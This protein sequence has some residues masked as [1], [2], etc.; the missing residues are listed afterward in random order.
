MRLLI[1][2]CLWCVFFVVPVSAQSPSLGGYP[3]VYNLWG[4]Y[5]NGADNNYFSGFNMYM[6]YGDG[7]N[8]TQQARADAIHQLN[9]NTKVLVT[10]DI[11]P[12]HDPGEGLDVQPQ[13]WSAVPG[14]PDYACILRNSSGTILR[15]DTYNAAI[16]NLTNSYCR[17]VLVAHFINKWQQSGGHFDGWQVDQA[18]ESGV[19]WQYGTD[20]DINVD[21]IPDDPGQVDQA[22][23]NGL[24]DIFTRLRTEFPQIIIHAN[25][26]PPRF[27]PWVNGRLYEMDLKRYLDKESSKSWSEIMH[28]WSLWTANQTLTPNTTGVMNSPKSA[29]ITA[30]YNFTN[31]WTAIKPA[32]MAEYG[33][34]YSRMRFGLA[35][36][37]MAGTVYSYDLS[38]LMYGVN[39]WYDEYGLRGQAA[40]TGYLGQPT[41]TATHISTFSSPDQLENGNFSQGTT[42]WFTSASGTTSTFTVENN[43]ARIHLPGAA[44]GWTTFRQNFVTVEAGKYYTVT[45]KAKASSSRTGGVRVQR[46]GG[47]W[48]Y[49]T[50]AT[51]LRFYPEWVSY[52]IPLKAT[53]SGDNGTLLFDTGII[54]GDIYFDDITF[55]EGV[56]GIWQRH[57]DSGT[58]LLN[59]SPVAQTIALDTSYQK[60]SG[61][62][63]PLYAQRLDDDQAVMSGNWTTAPASF[64]QWGLTVKTMSAPNPNATVTYTPTLPYAGQYEVLAW[65]APNPGYSSQATVTIHH[66]GGDT[67]V[68]VNQTTGT[69]G[70][71]SLGTYTFD[72]SGNAK[73]VLSATGTGTVVADAYKW[74]SLARYNDGSIVNSVTLQPDDAIILLNTTAPPPNQYDF[75]IDGDVDFIDFT[76]L[77]THFSQPFTIFDLNSLIQHLNSS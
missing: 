65:V 7:S 36:A 54:A 66:S 15:D 28:E 35:S 70:W 50:N 24:I 51:Q 45:F 58:V 49:I 17:D 31:I 44:S 8:P 76:H 29:L 46:A 62:Q 10:A 11:V 5:G 34:D 73:A 20:L 43:T 33:A 55:H 40:S 13:W 67:P 30:K 72:T 39:W 1:A 56:G 37:L 38:G 53:G 63:A 47:A 52:D 61:T 16:N 25:D 64:D 19:S 32:M 69:L 60:L 48:E 57:F 68:I 21:G 4:N 77:I 74:V 42:N 41:D 22:F 18:G 6:M 3:H 75:D 12:A 14:T 9:P 26:S 27:G 23:V 2:M 59:E 71:Y